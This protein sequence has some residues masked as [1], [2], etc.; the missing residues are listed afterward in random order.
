MDKFLA[1]LFNN[2][3]LR[4]ISYIRFHQKDTHI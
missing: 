1:P 2:E 4:Y 3:P